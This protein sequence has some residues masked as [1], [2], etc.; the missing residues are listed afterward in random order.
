MK[1]ILITVFL[2]ATAASMAAIAI[3]EAAPTPLR[4]PHPARSTKRAPD[5][6]FSVLRSAKLAAS[7]S[8]AALPALT[9]KRLTEPGTLVSELEL[10]PTRA[11]YVEINA[12]AHAWVIPGQRGICLAVHNGIAIVTVCG[13]LAS[14]DAGGLVIVKRPSSGPIIYGLVPD[15]ASVTVTNRDGSSGCVPVTDNVFMYAGPTVQSV[16]VQT[17]GRVSTIAVT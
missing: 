10:E 16:S 17:T 13:T 14:A 7:S 8:E 1:R 11:S 6:R 15:G 12:A 4:S 5:G 3:S 9:I 2:A